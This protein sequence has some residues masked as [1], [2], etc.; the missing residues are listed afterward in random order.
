MDTKIVF[1]QFDQGFHGAITGPRQTK[2]RHDKTLDRQTHDTT[3]PK[4]D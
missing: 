2:T 1:Q 3:S 4:H